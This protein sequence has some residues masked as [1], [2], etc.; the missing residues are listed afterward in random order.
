M[1]GSDP[2]TAATQQLVQRLA[3]E[4]A[5]PVGWEV[6][7]W[8]VDQGPS[9]TLVAGDD[10]LRAELSARSELEP[11]LVRTERFNLNARDPFFE[12]R[13]LG[14]GA[15]AAF[16]ALAGIVRQWERSL[17]VVR[18]SVDESAKCQ[19]RLVR[20]DRA[21]GREGRGQY[22]LNPYV[23]CT[24]GC[25]FCF[26][27]EAAD[28]SRRL[29]GLPRKSWGH[30]VDVKENLPEVLLEEVTQLQPGVVRLS[31]VVTDPYQP[32]EGRHRITRRCLQVLLEHGFS[33]CVL[34]RAARIADDIPLLAKFPKAWVGL[35]VPTDDDAIRHAFEPGADPIDARLSTLE[36]CQRGG[37][38]T[39]A[40]IQPM[41][42][43][44]PQRLVERLAPL[45]RVVRIDRMHL[46]DRVQ[47]IY[48]QTGTLHCTR[49]EW[50][51][52]T[53]RELVRG[54]E[55]RGVV[56]DDLEDLQ[57]LFAKSRAP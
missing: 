37:L 5:L 55:A 9:V 53:R 39:F 22:Y 45:I 40:V 34:T 31:P 28:L 29:S 41:L 49:P 3:T 48:S 13:S 44:E 52:Q 23:G 12:G 32:L 16:D 7:D 24:I 56:V 19:V 25:S 30:W 10:I 20:V 14:P 47:S 4:G 54:F 11:C 2:A 17:P 43:M 15:R 35:S 18:R 38:N 46:E 33:P 42:P 57:V 36:A 51:S 50:F 26:V 27:E 21:L 6:L 8:D 1:T